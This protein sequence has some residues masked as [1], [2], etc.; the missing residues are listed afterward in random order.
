MLEWLINLLVIS[1][2]A[3]FLALLLEIAHRFLADYGECR[4]LINNEQE[5]TV[6]GGS[7]LLFSLGENKIFIPSACG[8]RGTCAYCKVKVLEGGGPI[9][10]TEVPYLTDTEMADSVRLSCQVKVRNDLKIEIPEELFLIK[11]FRVLVDRITDLTPDIKG[12]DLRIVSPEEG[13]VF[14]AGQYVQLEVPEHGKTKEPEFRAYSICS[15]CQERGRL[16]LMITR[17]EEGAVSGYV[18][19]FL[20]QGDELI[21]RGPFGDFYYRDSDKD[22]LLI[23]TGSGLAPIRSILHHLENNGISR[24]TTLFLGARTKADLIYFE[25]LKELEKTR[26]DFTFVP[27]L[28]RSPENDRWE[29]EKGRVTDL[30]ERRISAG[31]EIEAYICGAPA[32]VEACLSLLIDKGV[33]DESVFFDKFA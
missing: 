20:K 7:P 17:V 5:L 16:E 9:L 23:A 31:A 19:D 22:L 32:M 15:P 12:L 11:E 25:E 4:I 28:S 30:I 27:A 33:A 10:P 8:G 26:P 24:K 29:G 14:K 13:I 6:I 21:L 3:A 2:V 18:H 1:G